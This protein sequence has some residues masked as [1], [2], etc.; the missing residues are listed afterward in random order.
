MAL[1]VKKLT[2]VFQFT[3][4]NKPVSLTDPNPEFSVEEVAKFYAGT[5]PEITNAIIEGP[6]VVG[7]N[8]AY[9]FTT[10]AGKLG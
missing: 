9:T 3:K 5:H 8:A 10:K 4:D 6:K 2:R 7:D 1:E